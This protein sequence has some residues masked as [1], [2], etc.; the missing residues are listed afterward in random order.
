[1]YRY[2]N[3]SGD[4]VEAVLWDGVSWPVDR[5]EWLRSFDGKQLHEAYSMMQSRDVIFLNTPASAYR[6]LPGEYVVY[7]G[8]GNLA[9]MGADAFNAVY[10]LVPEPEPEPEPAAA[11]PAAEE[12]PTE[13]D[14]E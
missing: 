8:A 11:A 4:I 14:P 2:Q 1:M 13:S 3:G 6:A 10:A 9:V 5:P 7:D 12:A